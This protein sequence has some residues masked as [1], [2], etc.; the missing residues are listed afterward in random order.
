[1]NEITAATEGDITILA[2]WMGSLIAHVQNASNDPYIMH[3]ESGYEDEFSSWFRQLLRAPET[4]VL[5]ARCGQVKVGFI[6]GTLTRPFMKAS[7]IKRIGQ[8]ELCW[9]EPAHRRRAVGT[10]L[11]RALEAWF[12]CMDVKY[13]DIQYMLSNVEAERSWSSLGYKPYRVFSRKQL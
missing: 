9:V 8:I 3:L 4:R 11:V 2:R 13:V 1:M 10:D 6:V 12:R 7:T 5:V